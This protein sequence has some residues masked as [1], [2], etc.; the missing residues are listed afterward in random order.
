MNFDTRNV[1]HFKIQVHLLKRV[2]D[3]L[4]HNFAILNHKQKNVRKYVQLQA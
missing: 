4:F 3:L 2:S 1:K